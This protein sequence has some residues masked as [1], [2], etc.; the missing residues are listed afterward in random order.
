MI[1]TM[2]RISATLCIARA[3]R[4]PTMILWMIH[5]VLFVKASL[6]NFGILRAEMTVAAMLTML[7]M[8]GR[9]L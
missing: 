5:K 6:R 4:A 3:A 9:I 1:A 7:Q 2:T 8:M